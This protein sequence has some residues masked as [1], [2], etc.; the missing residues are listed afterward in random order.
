MGDSFG[1]PKGTPKRYT[2]KVVV[3]RINKNK[4]A[5]MMRLT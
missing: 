5:R 4:E 1:A 2:K 3:F